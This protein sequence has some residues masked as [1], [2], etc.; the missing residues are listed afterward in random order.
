MSDTA[1]TYI[2]HTIIQWV[3]CVTEGVEFAVICVSVHAVFHCCF[4]VYE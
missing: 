1:A 2:D 3:F 4:T